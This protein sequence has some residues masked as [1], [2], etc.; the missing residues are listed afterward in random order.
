MTEHDRET[1][2]VGARV[3]V[4]IEKTAKGPRWRVRTTDLADEELIDRVVG[5]AVRAFGR[6]EEDL[7]R[8]A[9]SFRGEEPPAA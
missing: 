7:G 2:E 8:I 9:R 6:V 1:I 3:S 4:T 5:D